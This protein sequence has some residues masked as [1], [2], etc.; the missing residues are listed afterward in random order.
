MPPPPPAY[1]AAEFEAGINEFKQIANNLTAEQ[2][3]V[4]QFCDDGTGTATSTGHWNA[5]ACA[6]IQNYSLDELRSTRTLM[7][8]NIAT[9]D[10]GICCWK[11]R[12]LYWELR[13]ITADPTLS[14]AFATPNFPSYTSGHSDFSGA[15][16]GV[17]SYVFPR[18]QSQLEAQAQHA[19]LFRVYAGIHYP[20]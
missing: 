6:L 1:G 11:A 13:T 4:A 18:E 19:S 10:A 7:L 14:T 20:L 17:L 9:K 12:Y 2:L 5:I 8:M 15:P 16:A 3:Q